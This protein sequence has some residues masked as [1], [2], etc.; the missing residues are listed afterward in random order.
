MKKGIAFFVLISCSIVLLLCNH[1][2]WVTRMRYS[3]TGILGSDKYTYGDLYGMSY[4]PAFKYVKDN[5]WTAKPTGASGLRD[6]D[7][8][9]IGDSYLYSYVGM[10]TAYFPR[11]NKVRFRKWGDV[12]PAFFEP[13]P[14]KNRVLL[15]EC[16]ERNLNSCFV[17]TRI[18]P[19]RKVASQQIPFSQMVNEGVK[20]T[21]YPEK[22]ETNLDFTLFNIALFSPFKE[23]KAALNLTLFGRVSS[24]VIVSPSDHFL[25]LRETVDES[26]PGSSFRIYQTVEIEHIVHEMSLIQTAAK[27]KGYTHVVFTIMPNPVSLLGFAD[28]KQNNLI[29][30]LSKAAAGRVI[31]V[32]PSDRLRPE[33]EQNFYTSDS[34]WNQRGAGIWLAQMNQFL[35]TL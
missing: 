26:S 20:Q 7:L 19:I 33:A 28:K 11:A 18:F 29:A 30:R 12:T 31:L 21:L 5:R 4:L 22:I 13:K 3:T 34:H 15:V 1:I 25:F 2:E 32:D 9:I 23:V 17:K 16:V 24:E 14:T 35:D 6:L 27:A 8:D 10:D